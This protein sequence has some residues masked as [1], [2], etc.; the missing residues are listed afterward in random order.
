MQLLKKEL[1]AFKEQK[2]F[3]NRFPEKWIPSAF[4]IIPEDFSEENK[5]INST[6]KMVRHKITKVYQKQIE[7]IYQDSQLAKENNIQAIQSILKS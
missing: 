5:M 1:L 3:K 4:Q 7:L 6:L 2:E